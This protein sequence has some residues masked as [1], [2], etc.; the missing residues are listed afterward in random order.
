[1]LIIFF[2]VKGVDLA[3]QCPSCNSIAEGPVVSGNL[4]FF[5]CSR[6][7]CRTIWS[8]SYTSKIHDVL[9][10]DFEQVR[11]FLR[12]ERREAEKT[13]SVLGYGR[14][15]SQQ[16]TKDGKSLVAE[17]DVHFSDEQNLRPYDAVFYGQ[18]LGVVADY[19]DDRLRLIFDVGVTPPEKGEIKFSEPLILYDSALSIISERAK[20]D[21]NHLGFFVNIPGVTPPAYGPSLSRSIIGDY[22]L[23]LEKFQVV[24]EI[25]SLGE[26]STIV[27]EGPPGT[28]KTMVIAASACEA[29]M[30]GE[31]VL[32]TSHTNVA[33]DNAL[34]RIL[35]LRPDLSDKIVRLGHPAKVSTIIKP[36][37]DKPKEKESKLEWLQR[38][39]TQKKIIGMTIA[40]LSVLDQLYGLDR[41]SKN[42]K[43]WPT[44]DYAFIDETSMVPLGLSVIPIY[45]AK[46]WVLLGDVRQLPPIVRTSQRYSG[47]W[48]I[49]EL[50]ASSFSERVRMLMIQ[51][52]GNAAIFEIVNRLFYHGHL[53]HEEKVSE[54]RIEIEIENQGWLKDALAPS[55]PVVWLQVENGSMDWCIIKRGK[56]HGASGANPAEASAAT[57]LFRTLLEYGVQSSDIAIITTYRAQANLIREAIKGFNLV[58]GEPII[59]SLYTE[60]H[61]KDKQV[62]EPD[63]FEKSDSATLLDMRLAETVDSYQGREKRCVIYS[64]TAHFNHKALQ[65]Y[66]RINVAVTRTKAK[67]II[68]SSLPSLEAIPWLAGIKHWSYFIKVSENQ[69]ESE[70]SLV[71]RIH[72]KKCKR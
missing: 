14:K 35:S 38:I 6:P 12:N 63:E 58:D 18:S 24:S 8:E 46:R 5:W 30:H 1:M 54:S 32:I 10:A 43:K 16:I 27:V 21:G 69:L 51:R 33:V 3:R 44:F 26:W 15:V 50:A 13:S 71:R 61:G 23:D 59:V 48:S 31:T 34:E 11:T 20:Y 17:L 25:A 9:P 64:L 57:K 62:V 40:K 47:A 42:M 55:H 29:A 7:T 49:L 67:L 2:V 36:F 4:R 41:L 52:R 19:V 37:I 56:I 28:G 66:R 53:R 22:N 60:A 65:D 72:S 70:A 39:F 45:Y 68:I